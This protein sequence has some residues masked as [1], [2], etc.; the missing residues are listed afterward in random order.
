MDAATGADVGEHAAGDGWAASVRAALGL[1]E[2]HGRLAVT[3]PWGAGKSALLEAL[4]AAPPAATPPPT[5]PTGWRR[6]RVH[7]RAGDEDVPYG[8]LAQLLGPGDGQLPATTALAELLGRSVTHDPAAL[9]RSAPR[10]GGDLL[11]VRLALAELLAA[12][13]PALLLVDGAQWV[14]AASADAL[15]YCVRTLP[16]DRI[17]VVAAERTT[18]HP[19][20][21]ARLL[22]GHPHIVRVPAADLT[23]TAAALH[24][25]GLPARWAA[26]VH[27][28]CG[29]HRAL[30]ATCYR[31]LA[32]TAGLPGSSADAAHGRADLP[33]RPRQ[34]RDL[35]T[36][37]L[38]T[39][40]ADVRAT[41]QVAALARHPDA[42]VLREAGLP[43]A[44]DHLEHA[45]RAGLFTVEENTSP[46]RAR[47]AAEALA[48]AAAE[49]TGTAGAAERRRIHSA[50]A[51]AVRDPLQRARHRALARHTADQ[52]T[53]EDTAQAAA[54]ARQSGERPL[55]AELMMLAARLT[56][57]DRPRLR[58]DRLADAVADAAAAG[59]VRLARQAAARITEDR[60]SPAQQV[61]ALLAVAD[62]HGQDLAET[63]PL[64]A[65]AR[66]TA[67]GDT[68]LLAAVELRA[69]VQTNVAGGD[70]ALALHH[71][72]AATEL[73]RAGGD[74]PLEAAALTMTA[75]M[76]RVL[77]RLEA[78]PVTLAAALALAVPPPR[79]GIRNSPE[80]LA[81]RHAVFDGRLLQARQDLIGLLPA[82][83]TSGEAEDLV[84]IWRSL[85]EVDTGLGSCARA[86]DWSA[87]AVRLTASAGLSPGP[88]WYSA[89]LAHSCGDTFPQA[90]R[91]A[92]QG[93]RASRQE[94]DALHTTRSLWILGAVLLHTGQVEHAADVLA[95][96]AELEARN[97]AADPAI[98]R[99]QAD[100]VEAFAASGRT[101]HARALLDR[102]Q[103]T[104]GPHTGHAVLRAGL[105]RA[106]ALCHQLS[107]NNEEAVELLEDAA[108]GF[109]RLG[110]P[111]EEG[112]THLARGRVERR[113]RRAAA[114]RNAWERARTLFETAGARPWTELAD[115]HL[116]RLAGH[117]PVPAGEPRTP[118]AVPELTARERRLAALVRVGATNQQAAQQMF[119]SVKTVET[120]LSRIYRKLG[121]SSRTQLGAALPDRP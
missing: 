53:A 106:R 74:V 2:R 116:S 70:A 68:A 57:A 51:D 38:A 66:R 99:W 45:A 36:A 84:D 12:G 20:A 81:A 10:S 22:G 114:A 78:A 9:A 86:L 14:D 69:A 98:L 28:Y 29:G 50:L 92:A 6:L 91:Y 7:T 83:Q 41:L 27:Q 76:E 104:V 48:E 111:V 120:T 82:A 93:V 44:D 77:G 4:S 101:E 89:A 25:L 16:A 13:P 46:V 19:A 97:G 90:L 72:G 80:Y 34:V 8:A 105:T 102:M 107:G 37:W 26:P 59:D 62:A 71:A 110:L 85:A 96:V 60:G 73:A 39:V 67:A 95:E 55:A 23:E 35:A 33:G 21:A 40:P 5:A 31:A 49:G 47:F 61:H 117:P 54:L 108:R 18:R 42:D 103:D 64:L 3:G 79:I 43:H 100:A 121:V 63:A 87:R 1:L 15:G 52:A 65:T 11:P 113:R 115:G 58:L 88:A 24:G 56:P 94:Q 30:L 17:A 118:G 32:E 75:R 112:R 109:A 119:V